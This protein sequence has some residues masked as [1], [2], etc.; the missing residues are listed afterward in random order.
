M[1]K[2]I[3]TVIM[4]NDY[5]NINHKNYV[6]EVLKTYGLSVFHQE[7]GGWGPCSDF[8]YEVWVRI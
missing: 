1:L 7:G 8:F 4:E 2:G 6:D 3:N 5:T